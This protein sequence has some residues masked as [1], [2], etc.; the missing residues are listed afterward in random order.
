MQSL[1]QGRARPAFHALRLGIGSVTIA[2]C[3]TPIEHDMTF[4]IPVLWI[5]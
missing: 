2:K 4:L 3:T 5:Q 1:S